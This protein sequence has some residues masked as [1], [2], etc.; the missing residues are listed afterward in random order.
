M[1]AKGRVSIYILVQSYLPASIT[2]IIVHAFI[3]SQRDVEANVQ[4]VS[5][6]RLVHGYSS[7]FTNKGVPRQPE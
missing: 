7:S 1:S 5:L 6:L 3:M 2:T 4:V